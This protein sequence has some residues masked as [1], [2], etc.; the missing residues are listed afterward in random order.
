MPIPKIVVQEERGAQLFSVLLKAENPRWG[1]TETPLAEETA[2]YFEQNPLP[3]EI[4]E[5]I[6]KLHSEGVDEETL[7]NLA[8]TY[9]HP[10]RAE[11]VLELA[12]KYKPHVQDPEEKRRMFLTALESFDKTFSASQLARKF[13]DAIAHD[14][15][16]RMKRMDATKT[17]IQ[18]IIDFFR[19][20]PATATIRKVSFVP[21]DPLYRQNSGRAFSAFPGEQII[22]SHIDNVLNQDHEFSHGLINPIVE[23]LA[24]LLTEEQERR[25]SRLASE[26]LRQDYGDGYFSLLCEELIRTYTELIEQGKHP[27]TRE[28]FAAKVAAFP[29]EEFQNLLAHDNRLKTR[30]DALGIATIGDFIQKSSEYFDRYEKNPLRDLIFQLYQDY[31]NRLDK[32]QN[33]EQFFIDE[34]PKRLT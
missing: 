25:I 4:A 3:S 2:A 21:T 33:F 28:E 32:E 19:P 11:K 23:K 29:E 1:E 8:L 26:K 27:E 22:I 9:Q 5:T 13:E 15:E 12:E 6:A 31:A 16:E 24:R 7:Y 18:N 30:C 34:L 10:E 20:D 17:R 14:K